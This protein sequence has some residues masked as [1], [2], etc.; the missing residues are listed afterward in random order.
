MIGGRSCCHS[1]DLSS[2]NS[3]VSC[4]NSV[5]VIFIRDYY[6]LLADRAISAAALSSGANRVGPES[7]T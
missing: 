4:C 1:V 5:V 6:L 2:L 3:V 7:I